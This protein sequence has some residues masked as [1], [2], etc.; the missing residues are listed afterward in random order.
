MISFSNQIMTTFE[1]QL[2]VIS[3]NICEIK[4]EK[5]VIDTDP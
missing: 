5:K 4:N 1:G 2:L 3:G